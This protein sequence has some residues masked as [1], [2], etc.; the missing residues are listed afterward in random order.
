ML[1]ILFSWLSIPRMIGIWIDSIAF[2]LIDNAYN[3]I[4]Y[5]AG[6]EFFDIKIINDLKE[7]VYMIV[8]MFALFRLALLLIIVYNIFE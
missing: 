7:N 5:F 1:D 8:F 2:S 4:V 6:N 3:L